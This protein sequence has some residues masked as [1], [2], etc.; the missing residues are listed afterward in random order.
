MGLHLS[1]AGPEFLLPGRKARMGGHAHFRVQPGRTGERVGVDVQIDSQPAARME[2]SECVEQQRF[3]ETAAPVRAAHAQDRDIAARG[4]LARIL[5]RADIPGELISVQAT[6]QSP[7]SY[8]GASRWWWRK[9]AYVSLP[10][11]RVGER[12]H[13]AS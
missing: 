4:I 3:P 1:A 12:L 8:A 10:S 6:N 7:A 9:S 13:M 2:G 5:L 11:P